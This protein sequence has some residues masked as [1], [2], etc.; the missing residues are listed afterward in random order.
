VKFKGNRYTALERKTRSAGEGELP[1][2]L[3]VGYRSAP[4]SAVEGEGGRGVRR[5]RPDDL[6]RV[7]GHI[8]GM[9]FIRD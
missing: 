1:L 5:G 6:D 9:P 3:L 7:L 8:C 4:S 2:R